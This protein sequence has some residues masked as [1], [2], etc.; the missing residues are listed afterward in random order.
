MP[1]PFSPHSHVVLN[2]LRRVVSGLHVASRQTEKQLGMSSAQ[3]FALRRL[4]DGKKRSL[5]ELARLTYTHQSSLSVVVRKLV[6][7][8][9]VLSQPAPEDSRRLTLCIS[10]KGRRYLA[11]ASQ[12][13][14]D[15]LL[16]A[17]S[18]MKLEDQSQLGMLLQEFL[19]RAGMQE[20]AAPMFFEYDE[21]KEEDN[22]E[23]PNHETASC[24]EQ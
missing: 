23:K 3:L 24:P 2:C 10:A 1:D 11:K 8:G 14:Q 18:S 7:K 15:Q 5:N 16:E 9:L 22:L 17:V 13:I 12:S 4:G 21:P 6:A 20:I 19:K